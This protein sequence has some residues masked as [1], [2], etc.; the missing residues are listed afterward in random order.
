MDNQG[1]QNAIIEQ[2][3]VTAWADQ[4]PVYFKNDEI[5]D[6]LPE[7]YINVLALDGGGQVIYIPNNKTRRFCSVVGEIRVPKGQGAGRAQALA[8][9]FQ[10]I[11]ENKTISNMRFRSADVSEVD[12]RSHYGINVFIPYEWDRNNA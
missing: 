2:T 9:D 3:F 12:G 1:S 6:T 4:T 8:H 11:F 7:E 10:E 5:P